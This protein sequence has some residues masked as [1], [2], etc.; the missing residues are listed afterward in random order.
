MSRRG[1]ILTS[2][3]FFLIIGSLVGLWLSERDASEGEKEAEVEATAEE[4]RG[5][6]YEESLTELCEAGYKEVCKQLDKIE[7]VVP[8][9]DDDVEPLPGPTGPA[10]PAG[11][12]GPQGAPGENGSEGEGGA[13]GVPGEPGEPGQDGAQGPVGPPGP[14]GQ[15]GAAGAPGVDASCEG[16]FVCEGE[17]DSILANYMTMAQVLAAINEQIAPLGCEVTIGG[18][19]PPLVLDCTITGKGNG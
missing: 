12:T 10:G 19:G 7:D 9:T 18:N 11:P 8:P 16:Q 2:A 5:D 6:L 17:L 14:P 4:K 1:L 13:A 3:A 15:D